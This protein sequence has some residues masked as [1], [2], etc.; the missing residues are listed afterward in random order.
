M[1]IEHL[2]NSGACTPMTSKSLLSR[3][4][5]ENVSEFAVVASTAA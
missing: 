2:E 3:Y 1:N 4:G 5:D